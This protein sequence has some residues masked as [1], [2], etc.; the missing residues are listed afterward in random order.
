MN[1]LIKENERIDDLQINNLKIIQNNNGFCFGID[2]VLLTDFARTIKNNSRIIDLGTGTGIIPILLTAKINAK[3]IIGIEIQED[4]AE[5]AQRSITL[6]NLEEK[7]EIINGDIKEERS[8]KLIELSNKN[9]FEYNSQYI[10]K[11]VE[12]LFEEEKVGI[13]KGHTQN[14][15]MVYCESKEKLDNTIKNVKCKKVIED[16]IVAEI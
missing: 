15:I 9:E 12:V 16:H 2:S 14:Y 1:N 5:M 3:K 11:E 6:N 13:Y 4:V 7:I 8:K 10:G